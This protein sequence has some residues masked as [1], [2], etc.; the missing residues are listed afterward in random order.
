MADLQ[1]AGRLQ[2]RE[3]TPDDY[4]AQTL[5]DL[6]QSVQDVVDKVLAPNLPSPVGHLLKP[7]TSTTLQ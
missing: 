7:C 1:Y 3:W 2:G 5:E 4:P 6:A